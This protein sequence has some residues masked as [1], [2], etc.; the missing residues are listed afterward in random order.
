MITISSK[1]IWEYI[2]YIIYIWVFFTGTVYIF[3]V[4]GTTRII[5]FFKFFCIF[6]FFKV[7]LPK[8]FNGTATNV[9]IFIYADGLD[10]DGW[11]ILSLLFR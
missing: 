8:I 9:N 6:M 10:T 1:F 3:I 11:D 5:F 2:L 4:F 7:Q